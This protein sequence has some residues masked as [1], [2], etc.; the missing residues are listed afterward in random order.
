MSESNI[1]IPSAYT[2][3]AI[4][5]GDSEAIVE[6]DSTIEYEIWLHRVID[7]CTLAAAKNKYGASI[8]VPCRFANR[9][10]L[11]FH[12]SYNVVHVT[13][14]LDAC[15][16]IMHYCTLNISWKHSSDSGT[17]APPPGVLIGNKLWSLKDYSILVPSI[18]TIWRGDENPYQP[19]GPNYYDFNAAMELGRRGYFPDGYRLPTAAEW[20]ELITK[21]EQ[22]ADRWEPLRA[23]MGFPYSG[24]YQEKTHE[25]SYYWIDEH[26]QDGRIHVASISPT[27]YGI[28]RLPGDVGCSIRLVKDYEA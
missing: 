11:E 23:L 19:A 12:R 28:G 18:D 13:T 27:G 5:R 17:F 2:L 15:G 16:R 1:K 21:H 24:I 8:E 25:R 6:Q 14:D 20:D 10:A 9:L 4:S 7:E 26:D 22:S 3:R